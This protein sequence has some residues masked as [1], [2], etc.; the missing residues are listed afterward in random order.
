MLELELSYVP[1]SDLDS[2]ALK[3]LLSEFYH[4]TGVKTNLREMRWDSAWADLMTIAT[5]GKGPD[6]SH[7]GGTWVSSL[8]MMNALRPFKPHEIEA[9]GGHQAFLAPT[10]QSTKQFNDARTWAIPW[11]GYIYVIC[12]RKDIFAKAGIHENMIFNDIALTADI[13]RELRSSG[14]VEIPWL[15]PCFPA[16][17]TDLLHI[18][19]SWVWS[20]GGDFLDQFSSAKSPDIV[21]RLA[22][23]IEIS[24]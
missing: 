20:A 24:G 17:S 11:T 12:Y 9:L 18:A 23:Q 22:F 13:L 6:I 19:A 5:H 15:N 1:D 14:A 10:W 16:P 7:I 2:P 8:A 3:V 4:K 21:E